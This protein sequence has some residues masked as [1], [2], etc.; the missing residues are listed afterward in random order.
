MVPGWLCFFI[1]VRV[2]RLGNRIAALLGKL[3]AGTYRAPRPRVRAPETKPRDRNLIAPSIASALPAGIRLPTRFAWMRR[4]LPHRDRPYT[5]GGSAVFLE[6]LLDQDTELQGYART[7]PA[8]ARQ[9]RP[10]CHMLGV[11]LPDYL[12]LPPRDRTKPRQPRQPR[13]PRK[14]RPIPAPPAPPPP[15][16]RLPYAVVS[17]TD[18]PYPDPSLSICG[19]KNWP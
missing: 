11:R 3:R 10:L 7:C 12:K 9:L 16:P 15:P 1:Q 19:S 17:S 4:M 5:V 8:L 6:F 2:Q 14:P 13:A 18:G